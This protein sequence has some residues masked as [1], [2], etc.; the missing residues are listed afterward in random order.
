MV[1]EDLPAGST[2]SVELTLPDAT[3]ERVE[4]TTL[5]A[6]PGPELSRIATVSDVHVGLD[7][8]GFLK[9]IRER[10]KVRKANSES[11]S[12][13]CLRAALAEAVEWGADLIVVKGDLTDRGQIEEWEE[14]AARLH[15]VDVPVVMLPGNHDLHEE[16]EIAPADAAREHSVHVVDTVDHVD[17]PGVRVVLAA[18]ALDGHHHGAIDDDL[19]ARIAE[20]A[21]GGPAAIVML[22]HQL[23]SRPDP[24][25]WPPGI[26]RDE[27]ERLLERLAAAQPRCLVTSGHTH[28]HRRRTHGPVT[29]TT[30]GS[31]KDYPGVWAGYAIHAA[32]I[33][34]VVRRVAA[35]DC[36][37]WTEMTRR[38]AVHLWPRMA[39]GS[40]GDRC[41]T[42]PWA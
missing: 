35:P 19:A 2:T 42:L 26:P 27:S 20:E 32:G 23:H 17:L 34:Q 14:A 29:V 9:T 5:P 21:A 25:F 30:V 36:L 12:V 24:P 16:A 39:E 6:L 40:L 1:V 10:G 13:R 33:R 28:R 3:T 38:G 37:R 4:V 11:P 18:T 15:E 7:S 31:T 41:F 8:F 22:H